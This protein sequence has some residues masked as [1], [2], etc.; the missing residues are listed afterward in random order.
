MGQGLGSDEKD[1]RLLRQLDL[2]RPELR[3]LLARVQPQKTPQLSPEWLRCEMLERV[4]ILRGAHVRP[5]ARVLEVGAG[6]QAIGTVPL[7]HFVGGRGAVVAAERERWSRLC[8]IVDL[9]GVAGVVRPIACDARWL[10]LSSDSLDAAY[11]LH[12]IRSLGSEEEIGAVFREM[13]RVAPSIWVAESLPEGRTEAQRAHLAMYRVR[14]R[15]FAAADGRPDDRPYLPLEG[16]VALVEAS[17]GRVLEASTVEIDLPHALAYFP[18]EN[19]LRVRDPGL[20]ADLERQWD[21]ACR[22][23]AAHGADH[24]PVG[25]VSATR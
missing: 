10:P 23:I 2:E 22:L 12:A 25:V 8:E 7:A 1:P 17:G 11:V 24:P 9:A 6:P 15:F 4:Q 3:A 14:S 16:L 19:L 5:G 20:R 21:D 13:L 18:R